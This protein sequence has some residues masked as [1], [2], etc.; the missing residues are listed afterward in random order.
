M[1][2]RLALGLM[3]LLRLLPLRVLAPIGRTL[4]AVL[5]HLGRERREVA[6][7]NLQLCFPALKPD[8]RVALAK[9][10]FQALARS[11]LERGILWWGS[12]DQ[13]HRLVRLEGEE[14]WRAVE[15]RPVILL[16]PHFVGF[17]MGGF[18]IGYGRPI[19]SM[20]S[21]QRDAGFDAAFLRG[22]TRYKNAILFSRQD[23]I[24]PVV[25]ALRSGIPFVYLPDMDFGAR[26]AVFVP[27]FDVQTAT[28]T[29]LS[30]LA[31]ISGAAVLP[32]I[33]R[34]L[35]GTEGYVVRIYPAW[36]DFPG[37]DAAHD[38]RRMNAF[39]EDRVREMPE[40]YYWV[41]K[42]FKTRPPGEASPYEQ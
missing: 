14:H 2:A 23:G 31:K 37:S 5:Y 18:R 6:L 4:G 40:Q 19:A 33:T 26:D 8:E 25:K 42:R 20:Y 21:R 41:H 35:P 39:I 28:I 22:R 13:I 24:R 15:K 32:C 11:L 12:A 9:R 38:A 16:M 7:V 1:S 36:E 30:R 10:H 34:Q 3:W 17:E 27:F 29:G